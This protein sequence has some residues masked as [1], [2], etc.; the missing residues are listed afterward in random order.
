[1][2]RLLIKFDSKS[3][4]VKGLSFHKTRPWLLASL[5][6][7]S[8][9]LWD[10]RVGSLLEKFEEHEGPVRGVD[11]HNEQPLFV[12][13]GDDYR[14]KVWDL[15]TR[16]SMFTLVGHLDYIR[17]VQFHHEYPW[18]VSASDDQT[19]RIWNWQNRQCV[20]V[21][22]GHNHYV[23]SA[24][25]HPK[26]DL[27][28]SASLDHTARVWDVS[29]LGRKNVRG[30]YGSSGGDMFSPSE[31]VVKCVLEGHDRGLNWANFHPDPSSNM[32]ITGADDRSVRLWRLGS[33][34]GTL[35]ESLRG[36]SNNVSSV[37]FHPHS[38]LALS[39]GEDKTI[40][41]WDVN[42]RIML[43]TFR[44]DNDRFWVVDAH[45]TR[46]LLAVGHDA[47]MIVFKLKRERPAMAVANGE[48]Y[49]HNQSDRYVRR[50]V[51]GTTA[52]VPVHQL[53]SSTG[54]FNYESMPQT[55]EINPHN[56]HKV[57]MLVWMNASGGQ[58]TLLRVSEAGVVTSE[59]G[60]AVDVCF[61]SRTRFAA[62]DKARGGL[63]VRDLDNQFKRQ[64]KYPS[65]DADALFS[66]STTGVLFVR[67][68]DVLAALDLS[69]GRVLFEHRGGR[70]RRVEWSP[71]GQRVALITKQSIV[72][73]EKGFTPICTY[74]D[75][76]RIK[77]GVWD[78][79][80]VF[81]FS[82]YTHVKYLLAKQGA[83]SG[84]LQSV[85]D[86]LYLVAADGERLHAMDRKHKLQS[87]PL[88]GTEYRF[89][90]ALLRQDYMEA[91]RIIRS[92]RL[93]GQA[94]LSYLQKSG[95]PE[96]AMHFVPDA[97]TKFSLALQCGNLEV[98]MECAKKMESSDAW[99][100]LATEALKQGNHQIVEMC[101]QHTRHFEKL[102][103]LYLLTGNTDNLRKMARIA[104][105][106]GDVQSQFHNALML[107]SVETRVSVL[108]RAGQVPLAYVTAATH[109]L[110]EEAG[111][112]K[113]A[114]EAAGLPVPAVKADATLMLP[115]VPIMKGENW[116]LL[117][118]STGLF[119]KAALAEPTTSPSGGA[120]TGSAVRCR[121]SGSCH[122]RRGCKR[123]RVGR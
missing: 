67:Q 57:N 43:S 107:G 3:A 117:A 118:V 60:K 111:R 40:R 89:K 92:G 114:L 45:P 53:G 16:R 11:F 97:K 52:D 39:V 71:S 5:H 96:V 93:C 12:S 98:A 68:A 84:I 2:V 58:Y 120:S 33:E 101:Y 27:I 51:M 77:S 35:V 17:T 99:N 4:R 104:E 110:E 34:R 119:E 9:Q 86:V 30:S 13:G 69:S 31:A 14:V 123:G 56:P 24:F 109:G 94:V 79:D 28:I 54:M 70:V 63:V 6:N 59:S 29:G 75:P 19:I 103:F 18:I 116:P 38:A 95:Y 82:T 61:V 47:G 91:V 64:Y 25:F 1:M 8:I 78:G 20:S 121:S 7:G 122:G 81:V 100:S 108:E 66:T 115:P 21:L 42:R 83:E 23:M 65:G 73:L 76:S 113:E 87:L 50:A 88:D 112:L 55:I 32:A 62:I 74:T 36:H 46:D 10:Y 72:L 22:T 105:V 15:N 85:S 26:D 37:I 106:R 80:D 90:L 48:V 44:R 102:S 41:V 49:Y